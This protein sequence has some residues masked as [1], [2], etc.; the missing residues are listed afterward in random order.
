[1][2]VE[3]AAAWL[4]APVTGWGQTGFGRGEV[5]ASADE[6]IKAFCDNYSLTDCK[7]WPKARAGNAVVMRLEMRSE[8]QIAHPEWNQAPYEGELTLVEGD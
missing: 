2:S 4:R 1:M 6:A 5:Y 7:A 3:I 8:M